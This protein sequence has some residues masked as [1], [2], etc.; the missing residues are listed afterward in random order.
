MHFWRRGGAVVFG[1]APP[2]IANATLFS[3]TIYSLYFEDDRSCSIVA[4]G[5]HDL[6]IIHPAVHD[7]P[8]LQRRVDIAADGIPRFGT[9]RHT[10]RPAVCRPRRLQA[11][12]VWLARLYQ[13]T[14][15]HVPEVIPLIVA[16][17]Q[18][19]ITHIITGA[20]AAV[21]YGTVFLL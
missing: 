2:F 7:A 15:T 21:R 3:F 19:L 18:K 14:R 9:E 13:R 8:A 6:V 1:N 20:F 17:K 12:F 10:I 4:A 11:D 16:V 5:N